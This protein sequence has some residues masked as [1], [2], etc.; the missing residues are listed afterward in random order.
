MNDLFWKLDR[1]GRVRLSKHFY[2]RQFLHSE[3]GEAF[4][5]PNVPDDTDLAIE[6][7]TK[8]CTEVLEPIV[9]QFGPIVVRSGFRCAKLNAFASERR[10][11]CAPNERNYGYHIWDH[12]DANGNAGAAACILV[13]SIVEQTED[14]DAWKR[15]A[16]W[17]D[18]NLTYH[19]MTFFKRDF[20]FNIGWHEEPIP[21]VHSVVPQWHRIDLTSVE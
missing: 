21:E 4:G 15:M 19:R 7:G 16:K 14:P 3:V 1:L 9:A 10:L 6:T 2:M 5:I 12:R 11:H 17:I 20:A 18:S 13:P 8:L